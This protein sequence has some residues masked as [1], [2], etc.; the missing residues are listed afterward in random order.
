M[1]VFKNVRISTISLEFET[2]HKERHLESGST[3]LLSLLGDLSNYEPGAS[4][5]SNV[6]EH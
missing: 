2:F 1:A 3:P 4:V 6:G 5:L